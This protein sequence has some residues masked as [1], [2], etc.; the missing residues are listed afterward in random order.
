MTNPARDVEPRA[1][2][3]QPADGS[4]PTADAGPDATDGGSVGQ[5]P[6]YEDVT[7]TNLPNTTSG[8]SMDARWADIDGDDDLDIV[9]AGEFRANTLLI[10]DGTGRFTDASDRLPTT[11]RD[12][13]DV[14]IHDFDGDDDLDLFF[15]SEDDQTN[16]LFLNEGGTFVDASDRIPVRG[17]S[18]AA[19]LDTTTTPATVLIGNAG[20][21]FAIRWSRAE[22][23]FVDVTAET[24][25][26][27]I[28][29]TQDL[30]LADIDDDGDLDLAVGNEDAS[31]ILIR[32][33]DRF[34]NPVTL[35]ADVETREIDVFDADGDDDLDIVLANIRFIRGQPRRNRLL[36]QTARLVFEDRSDE[37][38]PN[39]VR[40]PVDDDNTFDVDA[41]DIDR[42]GDFDLVT[43][44]LDALSGNP[45]NA[46][47]RV[48]L[49]DGS[50][51]FTEADDV[52]PPTAVG[53]GFDIEAADFSG[54]GKKDLYLASRGGTD[55]L[56]IAR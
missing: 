48:Y 32:E 43:A 51:W 23:R 40:L 52:L 36:L 1:D 26:A 47:Y 44:N 19:I 13:E 49:N 4:V 45:A 17:V 56:L 22:A 7:A 29:Q 28:D 16:E 53:N 27:R 31:V 55:R 41:I 39:G 15:A 33:G 10:N 11:R 21:N 38:G 9:V 46:P 24:L 54:D 3:G 18:N 14:V 6:L 35:P 20:Q 8:F 5:G 25:P 30:E 2:V 42:D 12:S 34:G 37:A 50:G